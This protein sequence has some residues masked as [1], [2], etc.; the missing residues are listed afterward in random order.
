MSVAA[1]PSS[2]K[3]NVL[4]HAWV[5]L[6]CGLLAGACNA[7]CPT[8]YVKIEGRCGL[9]AQDGGLGGASATNSPGNA[10]ADGGENGSAD[11]GNMP[12]HG[13]TADGG[14]QGSG[15]PVVPDASTGTTPMAGAG[16]AMTGGTPG[17]P[18]GGG[19]GAPATATPMAGTTG[20]TGNMASG[21]STDPCTGHPNETLCVKEVMHQCDAT[22][23]STT[24]QS[25]ESP[26]LCQVG[27]A[28]HVCGVCNPGSFQCMGADL[29]KCNDAG[30]YEAHKTCDSAALCKTSGD[31]TDM[32]CTPNSKTCAPDGTLKTCSG[33]GA[34]F[35]EAQ[36]QACGKDLCDAR[37]GVCFKCVPNSIACS[38]D[39][40][41][42]CSADGQTQQMMMC[43]S[44]NDCV[45]STC[46]DGTG[47][48]MGGNL[49]SKTQCSSG[50]QQCNGSGRCVECVDS[51]ACG[52]KKCGPRNTCV[53]CTSP[54]DCPG[55]TDCVDPVC[56]SD[57]QC[58]TTN[59]ILRGCFDS[60]G[61]S[62]SCTGG[63]CVC[64]PNC[65]NKCGGDDNGCQ[66]S[67]PNKCSA[68]QTCANGTCTSPPAKPKIYDSCTPSSDMQGDCD[69][70]LACVG[71]AGRGYHCYGRAPCSISQVTVFGMVC[72]QPCLMPNMNSS[73]CPA[74][75][76][77]C[78]ANGET[79]GD[80]TDGYCIP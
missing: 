26:M 22:G 68:G 33:D 70:G 5:L 66:G 38:G 63:R 21:I 77:Y 41:V 52:S 60:R 20:M 80:D 17:S 31:C 14:T 64:T 7:A 56:S 72:A 27:I 39:T 44:S 57:G 49:P 74:A 51:S 45:K 25:C 43:V 55:K 32:V 71:I 19:S 76:G 37:N 11:A 69:N 78:N 12:H 3:Q 24:P 18:S 79:G 73:S 4:L 8:G 13:N 1:L 62:G 36:N 16:G 50:G 58:S 9:P 34:A 67:C 59:A 10:L 29:Q 61:A 54:S 2:Q 28:T 65:T 15:N 48:G 53:E 35:L 6:G 40:A 75:A 47:C 42:K 46:T 30:Q 23:Q